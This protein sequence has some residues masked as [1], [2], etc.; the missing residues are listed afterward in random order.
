MYFDRIERSEVMTLIDSIFQSVHS[1]EDMIFLVQYASQVLPKNVSEANGERIWQ[2]I[3]D[4]QDE[5]IHK[6]EVISK[7][8][9]YLLLMVV[10][11]WCKRSRLQ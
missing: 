8:S 10:L 5:L 6:R 3:L 2:N 1:L 4:L 9:Y 7:F 11:F